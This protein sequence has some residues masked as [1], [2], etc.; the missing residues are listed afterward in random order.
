MNLI[1]GIIQILE[2]TDIIFNDNNIPMVTFR[3]RLPYIQNKLDSVIIVKSMI[4]GNLAQDFVDYYRL[5][6]YLL[7]EGYIS[8]ALDKDIQLNITKLYPFLFTIEKTDQN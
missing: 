5:N 4:W 8:I 3:T 6:D 7:I 1:N 2:I